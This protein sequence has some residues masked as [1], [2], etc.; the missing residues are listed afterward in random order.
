MSELEKQNAR[1]FPATI[2]FGVM[3]GVLRT[4]LGNDVHRNTRQIKRKSSWRVKLTKKAFS[5]LSPP[6]RYLFFLSSVILLPPSLK[7]FSKNENKI[8]LETGFFKLKKMR[9]SLIQRNVETKAVNK[10]ICWIFGRLKCLS[11]SFRIKKISEFTCRFL[12]TLKNP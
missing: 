10:N 11:L 2:L 7:T 1:L 12:S 4:L 3:T 8:L 5:H 9:R 6:H